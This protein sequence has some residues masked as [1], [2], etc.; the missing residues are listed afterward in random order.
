M[1]K[2][3]TI[4]IHGAK[5]VLFSL[6]FCMLF[7]LAKIFSL[8]YVCFSLAHIML[9]NSNCIPINIIFALHSVS[10]TQKVGYDFMTES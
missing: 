3:I 7:L 1:K 4:I 9:H 10:F 5:N 2:T 8:T 6:S